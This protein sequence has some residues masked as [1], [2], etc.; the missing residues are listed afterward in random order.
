[1]ADLRR[2]PSL[3]LVRRGVRHACTAAIAPN[4]AGHERIRH[5]LAERYGWADCWIAL[6]ADTHASLGIRLDCA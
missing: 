4:P 3:V 2:R 1:V 6:V 5:L